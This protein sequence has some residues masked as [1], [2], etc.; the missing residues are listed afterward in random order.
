[1]A[2]PRPRKTLFISDLND[3]HGTDKE[4]VG[5]IRE[6]VFGNVYRYIKNITASARLVGEWM[7]YRAADFSASPLT[8]FTKAHL[9]SAAD[10][11]IDALAGVVV[12]S[13]GIEASA[14]SCFGWLLIR[15]FHSAAGYRQASATTL[16]LG[17][18][19]APVAASASATLL[20]ASATDIQTLHHAKALAALAS[21]TVSAAIPVYVNCI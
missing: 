10:I 8:A 5:T 6:D 21:P 15:G 1:M 12:A 9:T 3:I 17:D 7:S 11:T 4:G 13:G 18:T 14:S 16:A 20:L 2:V 19:I